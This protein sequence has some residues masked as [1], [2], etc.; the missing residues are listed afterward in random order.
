MSDSSAVARRVMSTP[1][2]VAASPAYLRRAGVPRTPADLAMH[3]AIIGASGVG[4]GWTFSRAGH[5]DVTLRVDGQVAANQNEAAVASA[6]AG[7]GIVAT[8]RE[9]CRAELEA[10]TL[11]E[12]LPEWDRGE[13]DVHAVLASGR[14]A[15]PAAKAFTEFLIEALNPPRGGIRAA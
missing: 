8:T 5:D 10:G 12:L 3:R 6:V 4:P 9:G 13:I 15:K 11:V 14:A 2:V 7:L 1:R